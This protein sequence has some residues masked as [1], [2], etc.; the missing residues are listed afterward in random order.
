MAITTLIDYPSV[1]VVDTT[2]AT[3]AA[4]P[5]GVCIILVTGTTSTND[6]ILTKVSSAED[7]NTKFGSGSPSSKYAK[8][9]FENVSA[10]NVSLYAYKVQ[11]GST[12]AVVADFTTA[13]T[14]IPVTFNPGGIIILPEFFETFT[15]S[16]DIIAL[17]TALNTFCNQ[18]DSYWVSFVDLPLTVTSMTEA[19]TD[20]GEFTS[21]KG[22]L[23]VYQPWYFGDS[24]STLKLLPSAARAASTLSLWSSGRFESV[25]AGL[26]E[27]NQIKGCFALGYAVTKADLQLAHA[28][29]INVI[30]YFPQYG[31]VAYDSITLSESTEYYQIN[32][33]VC[34]R[35]VL[36]L[37]EQELIPFVNS[38]IAGN[39]EDLARIEA[40]LNRVLNAAWQSGYLV[41]QN[42]AD[43]YSV[44][45]ELAT[46][47]PPNNAMLTFECAIRPSYALQKIKV[48]VRNKL[49]E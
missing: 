3:V 26:D 49:G 16:A 44:V 28:N 34:L 40:A 23:M 37:I 10:S 1:E 45:S 33:V 24:G 30:K 18:D 6:K 19:V 36:Y 29:G 8:A 5:Y 46:L 4:T 25:P 9:F 21:A 35:I 7:F 20:R 12:A 48:Y 27:I 22:C 43:A 2:K 39:I 38:P 42:Q 17:S 31:Y 32:S 13:L 14:A 15:N 47:P 41:G 11:V